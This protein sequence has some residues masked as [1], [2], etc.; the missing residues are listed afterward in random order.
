VNAT[1][2]WC[3]AERS[4][5]VYAGT[6]PYGEVLK[7]TDLV[8]WATYKTVE[9]CHA[10]SM[11]VWANALFVG[12]GPRGR[13]Y[14]NNFTSSNFY[15]FVETEDQ[16]VTSF[17]SFNG[18][19]Y[20]GT[21][22]AGVVYTFDGAMWKKV[23]KAYG[24]INSM[25]V[26]GDKLYVLMDRTETVAVSD[27]TGWNVLTITDPL[28]PKP[29]GNELLQKQTVASYR[30]TATPPFSFQDQNPIEVV[31][32]ESVNEMIAAGTFSQEDRFAVLPPRPETSLKSA[33]TDAVAGLILGGS[34]GQVFVYDPSKTALKQKFGSDGGPVNAILNLS[35]GHN[36]VAIGNELFVMKEVQT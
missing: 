9:D 13:I 29:E 16:V 17:A 34:Q 21:S 4:G 30:N 22:P 1:P 2:V 12:T 26:Q 28:V 32:L 25:Q 10:R 36:I 18:K 33:A 19:L 14:V 31:R 35:S 20:A 24:G 11:I 27:G 7:S 5:T 23:Y 15:L 6:G 3:F 8:T